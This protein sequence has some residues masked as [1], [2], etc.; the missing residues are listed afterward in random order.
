MDNVTNIQG[1]EGMGDIVAE[2][3]C[4]QWFPGV[5]KKVEAPFANIAHVSRS[6]AFVAI[7]WGR[8]PVA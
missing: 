7:D 8:F 4:A 1:F 5:E 6:N 2:H 3:S